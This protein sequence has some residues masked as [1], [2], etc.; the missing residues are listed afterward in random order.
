MLNLILH[1]RTEIV[2]MNCYQ[3]DF[4]EASKNALDRTFFSAWAYEY[5]NRNSALVQRRLR[6]K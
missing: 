6:A 5:E 4:L 2:N 1:A 3:A